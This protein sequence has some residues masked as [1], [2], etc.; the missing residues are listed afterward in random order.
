MTGQVVIPIQVRDLTHADLP[1]CAWAG[2]SLHLRTVAKELE[3]VAA[4][5]AEYLAVCVAKTD[6]PVAI[7]GIDYEQAVGSG[8]IHQLATM[9]AL[10]SRGFGT[11][12]IEEAEQRIRH[13]GLTRAELCVEHD[14]PRA[15]ALYERLGYVV[16]D[17]VLDGWDEEKLDGTIRRY[18]TMCAVLAKDLRN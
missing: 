17:N 12:L 2:T 6:A 11:A 8:T 10:Q 1:Y 16:F 3:R 4:G 9:P 7:G 18:E 5:V 15:Q 14:N 13:R